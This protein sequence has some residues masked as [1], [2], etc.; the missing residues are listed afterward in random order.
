VILKSKRMIRDAF[1]CP[2]PKSG[3]QKYTNRF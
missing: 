2:Q 3:L 1:S